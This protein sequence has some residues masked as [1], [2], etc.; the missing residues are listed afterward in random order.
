MDK[1]LH[2]SHSLGIFKVMQDFVHQPYYLLWIPILE[3]Y[4]NS[5]DFCHNHEI[6]LFT[7]DPYYGNL[8]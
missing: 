6:I 4:I 7:I 3:T 5:R 1:I 2:K 8:N